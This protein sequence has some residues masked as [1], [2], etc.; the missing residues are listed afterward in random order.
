MQGVAQNGTI[1]INLWW[2]LTTNCPSKCPTVIGCIIG[3]CLQVINLK[4]LQLNQGSTTLA[5]L[6]HVSQRRWSMTSTDFF[7]HAWHCPIGFCWTVEYSW[8]TIAPFRLTK[9]TG[10]YMSQCGCL[11]QLGWTTLL[12]WLQGSNRC[13]PENVMQSWG[14]VTEALPW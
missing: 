8:I 7:Y 13:N 6:L 3:N 2:R 10:F 14:R 1:Y 9:T 4:R 12:D 11:D 5:Q